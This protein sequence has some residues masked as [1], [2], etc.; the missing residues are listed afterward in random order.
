ME[1]IEELIYKETKSRLK[2]MESKNYKFPDQ[3]DKG[4]A[5]K[6]ISAIAVCIILIVLCMKIGR[7]HV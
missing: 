2:E 5:V 1:S 6:I 4:D 7:A 3:A